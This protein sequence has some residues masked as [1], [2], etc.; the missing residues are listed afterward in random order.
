MESAAWPAAS[1][2]TAVAAADVVEVSLVALEVVPLVFPVRGF[3]LRNAVHILQG[4]PSGPMT[5]PGGGF[6][7][8]AVDALFASFGA[9]D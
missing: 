5:Q 9:G 7:G 8:L 4:L 2:A 6:A 3:Q 1:V